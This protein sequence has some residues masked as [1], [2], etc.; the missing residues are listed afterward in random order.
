MSKLED[1]LKTLQALAYAKKYNKL[2]FYKPYPK[3][4]EFHDLGATKR[5]RLFMAGN[6]IGKTW[7][8]AFE[9]AMHLTGRYP[10]WWAGK[11]FDKPIKAWAVGDGSIMVRDTIQKLLCGEAGVDS[12]FGT[13]A[14]PKA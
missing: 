1:N 3:Q 2:D 6:Q 5:E 11:R 13:G 14:I 4:K 9:V 7:A 8:G 10:D 12:A